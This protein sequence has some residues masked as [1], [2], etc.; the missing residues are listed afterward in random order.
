MLQMS[1]L[2][3]K[4]EDELREL[5]AERGVNAP[6]QDGHAQLLETLLVTSCVIA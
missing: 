1:Q 3:E 5:L 6:P 4:S 2:Q